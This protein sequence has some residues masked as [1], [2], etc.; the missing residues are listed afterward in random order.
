MVAVAVG[1]IAVFSPTLVSRS[2]A[3]ISF[4]M[5]DNQQNDVVIKMN[6]AVQ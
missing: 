5:E 1:I 3:G 6:N 4:G 2:G